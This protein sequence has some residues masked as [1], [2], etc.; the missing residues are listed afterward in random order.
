MGAGAGNNKVKMQGED[1][2]FKPCFQF[3]FDKDL[4]YQLQNIIQV[5]DVVAQK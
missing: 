2:L 1:E 4:G 5:E 3:L